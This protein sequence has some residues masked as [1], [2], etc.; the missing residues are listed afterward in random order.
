MKLIYGL[1]LPTQHKLLY[2]VREGGGRGK[3]KDGG[4][5]HEM[6]EAVRKTRSC[7]DVSVFW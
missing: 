4:L 1:E 3:N 6:K 7:H 2:L 5:P